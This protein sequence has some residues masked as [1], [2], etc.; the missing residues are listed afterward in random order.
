MR[1]LP[2][3]DTVN[4]M[5]PTLEYSLITGRFAELARRARAEHVESVPVRTSWSASVHPDFTRNL[6][7]GTRFASP[8]ALRCRERDHRLRPG[9]ESAERDRSLPSPLRRTTSPRVR[10]ASCCVRQPR[11]G[12]SLREVAFDLLASRLEGN[13]K[14]RGLADGELP[15]AAGVERRP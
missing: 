3:S 7:C 1:K 6:F 12:A 11:L 14:C 15:R 10:K 8:N 2:D 4:P 5:P 13:A 9:L